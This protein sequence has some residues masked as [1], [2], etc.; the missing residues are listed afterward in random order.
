M[1]NVTNLTHKDIKLSDEIT[2]P[3]NSTKLVE[4][5]INSTVTQL[6]RMGLIK[7][8]PA[9]EF[10]KPTNTQSAAVDER[11]QRMLARRQEK[12]NNKEAVQQ[13]T[14]SKPGPKRQNSG[15]SK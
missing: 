7:V 11:K 8:T 5:P 15:N 2:I 9:H 1:E 12:L 3:A 6:R 14:K 13:P 4:L 10:R